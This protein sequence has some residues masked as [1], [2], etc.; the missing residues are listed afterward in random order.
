MAQ[1]PGNTTPQNA[2]DQQLTL[3]KILLALI[4]GGPSGGLPYAP[5]TVNGVKVVGIQEVDSF[6]TTS[7]TTP[8]TVPAGALSIGFNPSSDFAG[9][10]QGATWTGA[11]GAITRTAQPGNTCPA[12]AI[13]CSGGSYDLY[14][15]TPA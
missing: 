4:G 7:T 13:T 10:I 15:V 11:K 5:P 2:D 14:V 12:F 8:K 3:K 9:T 6:T 1:Y